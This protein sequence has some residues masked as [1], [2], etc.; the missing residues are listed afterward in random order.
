VRADV[1]QRMP[2]LSALLAG[3]GEN[4]GLITGH[5]PAEA[6]V[7]YL[8]L[9]FVLFQDPDR[10]TQW[11]GDENQR[12]EERGWKSEVATTANRCAR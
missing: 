3:C 10:N 5:A 6:E 4:S 12:S 9:S 7:D 1:R 11:S 2:T 8:F